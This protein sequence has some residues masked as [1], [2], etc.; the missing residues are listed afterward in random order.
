MKLETEEDQLDR[1]LAPVLRDD[2]V[3]AVPHKLGRIYHKRD[4]AGL[5]LLAWERNVLAAVD[6]RAPN[7]G[8]TRHLALEAYHEHEVREHGGR[9][10]RVHVRLADITRWREERELRGEPHDTNQ[11]ERD[12]FDGRV[13]GADVHVER[14]APRATRTA[15]NGTLGRAPRE[16]TNARRRGSRRGERATPSSS[17]DPDPEP[18]GA[19]L[20]ACGCG[21]DLDALG[22]N[23]D[24]RYANKTCA[25]RGQRRRDRE[26]P[27]RVVE[28]TA[29]PAQPVR[30]RCGGQAVYPLDHRWICVLCGRPIAGAFSEVNGHLGDREVLEVLAEEVRRGGRAP[31][32]SREWRT[33][34][35]RPLAAKLRKT[36]KAA[37]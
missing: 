24:A 31:W 33:R 12:L 5:P 7:S 10:E 37:T 14:F 25:K 2:G 29:A 3:N 15:A 19:R 1:W 6:V 21:A 8:F 26:Q 9:V 30:C 36:R 35:M 4:I 17:D 28:R 13:N 11:L 20:C 22:K 18:P 34:P 32:V 27:D 16:A 23:A